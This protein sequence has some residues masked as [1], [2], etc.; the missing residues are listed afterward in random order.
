MARP[1]QKK[2]GIWLSV[3]IFLVLAG[4]V[5]ATGCLGALTFPGS[6]GQTHLAENE[7]KLSAYFLDVGQGDSTLFI[8]EGKTILID[9]GEV[10]MGD[11]VVSD[12]RACNIT[13]IDLLVATHPHSD[14]I[15]GMQK[16]PG[17]FPVGKVLDT[18]LPHPSTLY[19]HF[20]ET[21]E[22]KHIPYQVAEQGQT[23]NVDPALR[24]VVLSP[25]DER[26]GENLNTD[27]IVLRISYGTIDFLMTGDLDNAGED[28]LLRTG[29]PV[30]AEILKVGHHGS[31]SS[32]SQAFL[33][34]VRSGDSNHF[35]RGGQPLRPPTYR[36]HGSSGTER[37]YDIPH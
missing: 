26:S 9:A 27:S 8:Y 15:G 5:I 33:N 3:A 22:E 28:A 6:G 20:L 12:L 2:A 10:D 18:G 7:G 25:P 37:G 23:I 16:V 29:Y 14:H 30:D 21:I 17:A 32:T 34:R 11:Q 4:C 24:V 31:S 35:R 19:E 36:D 1:G 13:R